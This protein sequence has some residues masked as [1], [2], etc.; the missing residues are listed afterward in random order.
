MTLRNFLLQK[1]QILPFQKNLTKIFLI[2]TLEQRAR[3]Q[4]RL[5]F[6]WKTSSST[7]ITTMVYLPTLTF[8]STKCSFKIRTCINGDRS[9][10]FLEGPEKFAHPESHS[11]ISNVVITELFYSHIFTVIQVPLTQRISDAYMSLFLVKLC[12]PEKFPGLSKNGPLLI[13]LAD[14]TDFQ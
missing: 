8:R 4:R 7:T 5:I 2:L 14:S 3:R 6:R 11:E 1:I 12:R 10:R 13:K 9:G